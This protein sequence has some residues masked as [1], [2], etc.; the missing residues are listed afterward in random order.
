MWGNPLCA[1]ALSVSFERVST[2]RTSITEYPDGSSPYSAISVL[3]E[4]SAA[5][6]SGL[7]TMLEACLAF[8]KSQIIRVRIQNKNSRCFVRKSF[9][10][11]ELFPAVRFSC[12]LHSATRTE[13][14]LNVDWT[15]ADFIASP[16]MIRYYLIMDNK[17]RFLNEMLPW[18][19]P[20]IR[21]ACYHGLSYANLIN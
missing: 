21:I 12:P 19:N 3:P 14:G 4:L 8:E 10:N 2:E 11:L 9:L 7:L 15:K 20:V 17:K 18:R 6:G 13:P 16:H 1:L 5:D